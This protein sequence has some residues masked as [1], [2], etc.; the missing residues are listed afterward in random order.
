MLAYRRNAPPGTWSLC[1]DCLP[2]PSEEAARILK[3]LCFNRRAVAVLIHRHSDMWWRLEWCSLDG[4]YWH[5]SPSF[6]AL[7][8][9]LRYVDEVI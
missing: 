9:L 8:Q 4:M 7:H 1:T 3:T 2:I 5:T 6:Y